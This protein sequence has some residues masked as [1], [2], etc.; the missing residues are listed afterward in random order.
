MSKQHL[1]SRSIEQQN[2]SRP[3]AGLLC[4]G[5]PHNNLHLSGG[6]K[7]RR[8]HAFKRVGI[9]EF[10]TLQLEFIALSRRVDNATYGDVAESALRNL[11]Q[12]FP[13]TVRPCWVNLWVLKDVNVQ[14]QGLTCQLLC[15]GSM[16]IKH[17]SSVFKLSSNKQV[18]RTALELAHQLSS[19][20]FG[21]GHLALHA[22][23]CSAAWTAADTDPAQD[24]GGSRRFSLTAWNPSITMIAREWVHAVA[25]TSFCTT[26]L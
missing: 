24:M 22:K 4:A 15:T 20:L 18:C 5:I 25:Q 11:H 14:L 6:Q 12:K 2:V 17:L 1:A 13:D 21:S 16:L 10:G 26:L 8:P 23:C 19:P 9:A 3:P 7:D